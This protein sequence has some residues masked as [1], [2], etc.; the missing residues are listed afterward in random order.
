[1]SFSRFPSLLIPGVRFFDFRQIDLFFCQLLLS[2]SLQPAVGIAIGPK[3]LMLH[4]IVTRQPLTYFDGHFRADV[5]HCSSLLSTKFSLTLIV[6]FEL[7][8]RG[9]LIKDFD[10]SKRRRRSGLRFVGLGT[11]LD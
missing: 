3:G 9:E 2:F 10:D 1:M 4:G 11:R 8:R 7:E 6:T 5:P